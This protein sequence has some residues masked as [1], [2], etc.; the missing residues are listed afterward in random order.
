MGRKLALHEMDP[1]SMANLP[2]PV[3]YLA[4]LGLSTVHPGCGYIFK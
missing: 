4:E 3:Y 1:D 2:T